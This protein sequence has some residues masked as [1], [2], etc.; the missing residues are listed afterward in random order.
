MTRAAY[1][2]VC[3][4]ALCAPPLAAGAP[5][6]QVVTI[7]A[8]DGANLKGTYFAASAPGPAVLLLHMCNTDRRSWEPLARQLGDAGIH[9][10]TVDY[11]GFGESEGPAFTSLDRVAALQAING[12]WPG[13]IDAA[14]AYLLSRPGVD[15]TRVGVAGGSCG[16]TQAVAV[17]RRHKSVRSLVLLAGPL[18]GEG[19]RFLLHNPWLPVFA[20]AAADDQYDAN[21]PEAMQ[22]LTELSGNPRNV[23]VGYADGKH[24][25]EMFIPHPDLPRKIVDWFSGT[26]VK[27]L[28]SPAAAVTPRQTPARD[29]WRLVEGGKLAEASSV[30]HTARAGDPKAFLFPE[31][32][33][34]LAGYELLQAKKNADAVMLF[35][36]NTEAY[37]LSA[38][39]QDS[40]GDGYLADGQRTLALAAA[41]KALAL[42][43]ADRVDEQTKANIRKSAEDKIAA[44]G[45]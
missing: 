22:W 3:F 11:R 17:A 35:R 33:M 1:G 34:N 43:P 5:A 9:A 21:A 30:F 18:D 10:L 37:P 25:T 13:D 42:L 2:L 20:S 36:L 6:P 26:L 12:K 38:N 4:L 19:R 41:Q 40:L 45:K 8:P 28:A 14:L 39:A 44:I 32:A 29:F 7:S 24:G 31:P 15:A 23:F 27:T 16:V